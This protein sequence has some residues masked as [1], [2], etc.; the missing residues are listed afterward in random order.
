[1]VYVLLV[2]LGL[3]LGSFINAFVWRLHEQAKTKSK[4]KLRELSITKGRSMCVQC[5]HTLAWY[6]LIPV[7]SWITL[8]GRCRYCKKVISWQYPLV[9]LLVAIL[10]PLSFAF[11][12]Y[13]LQGGLAI[14]ALI[15]WIPILVLLIALSIYDLKWMILPNRLM[16]LLAGLVAMQRVIVTFDVSKMSML[17]SSLVGGL[18]VGG[19]FWMM[20]QLS[21]G[22][23]IGGGD[24]RYGFI[25]G[26]L[27]GWQKA[28]LGLM[29]AS[30]A[31]TIVV[32][33]IMLLGKYHKKM[34][35]P[36]GPFLITAT[37]VS[38]LFGQPLIDFYKRLSGM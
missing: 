18:L 4:K 28:L 15:L 5:H 6:D 1:M 9:E 29:I 26:F 17:I 7:V 10:L 23:W 35:V 24:V 11:W 8:R 36:F 20:F 34:R 19:F 25:M 21:S 2:F 30:Y 16:Y 22:K 33:I 38:L 27:L 31:G 32:V 13:S 37:Y 14:T 12:P 3:A